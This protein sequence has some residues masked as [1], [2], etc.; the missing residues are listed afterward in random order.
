MLYC[1]QPRCSGHLIEDEIDSRQEW[2]RK[3]LHCK[4]CNT[5]YEELITYKTQSSL[6][7]SD[8]LFL[9]NE[10]GEEILVG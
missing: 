1:T 5:N 7:A 4:V 6:I 8:E 2:C 3:S 10:K 9:I